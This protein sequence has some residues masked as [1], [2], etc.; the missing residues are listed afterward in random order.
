MYRRI[1]DIIKYKN[2]SRELIINQ[3]FTRFFKINN[4]TNANRGYL[5][6]LLTLQIKKE[7]IK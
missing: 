2:K 7:K 6:N 3:N 1:R 4:L 5:L